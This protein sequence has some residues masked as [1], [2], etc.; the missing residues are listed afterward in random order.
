ML[1]AGNIMS[2]RGNS[3]S[4]SLLLRQLGKRFSDSLTSWDVEESFETLN[5]V[6]SLLVKSDVIQ[7]F[8]F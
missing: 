4:N 8:F 5:G 1:K 2:R 7:G 3:K 6:F